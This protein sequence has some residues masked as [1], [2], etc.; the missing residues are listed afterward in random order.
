[1]NRYGYLNLA[2]ATLAVVL[3]ACGSAPPTHYYTLVPP[4]DSHATAGTAASPF[5]FELLP[6][7]IPAQ[8]DL[9]QMVVRQGGQGIAM[10]QGERW[11]APLGDEVRGAL[12]ADLTRD[13]H[14]QDV[15]GLP[16]QGA[17][18][19]RIKLDVRR[20]D[21]VPGNSATIDAAW[22]VRPLKGGDA[23]ACTSRISQT[24]GDGYDALVQGHQ[25][26]IEELARQIGTVAGTMAAGHGASCPTG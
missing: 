26:A 17:T 10:V 14:A 19:V 4:A 15:T 24:V 3:G 18:S 22:S 13:F 16:S 11:I 1:M 2:V 5:Q 21:S 25:Q 9:P 6:V 23:L 7:T 12:S 8:V 20:F